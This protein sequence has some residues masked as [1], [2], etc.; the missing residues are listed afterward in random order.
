MKIRDYLFP[1]DLDEAL[2]VLAELGDGALPVA[3]AT[4]LRFFPDSADST[5]VAVDITRIGLSGIA[6]EGGVFRIGA[7]TV[8]S[9]LR[10]RADAGWALGGVARRMATR[11]VRNVST[12][13]GNVARVFPWADLPV[14]LLALDARMTIASHGAGA[15]EVAADEFFSSQPARLFKGG[16]LLAQ[17]AVRALGNGEG[18]GYRKETVVSAGFSMMT[19]AALLRLDGGGAVREARVAAGAALSF[20]RRLEGAE[21]ALKGRAPGGA[22]IEAAAEAGTRGLAWQGREGMSDEYARALARAAVADALAEARDGAGRSA[23]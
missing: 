1:R 12:I 7:A 5:R 10:D 20:P 2:A 8:V 14:A 13:G 15:R 3:G 17:V 4:S 11:Q 18:F 6:L 19:A 21:A 22:A 9:D 23:T 16:A